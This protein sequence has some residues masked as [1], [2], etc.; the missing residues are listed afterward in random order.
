MNNKVIEKVGYIEFDGKILDVYSSLNKPLFCIYDVATLIGINVSDLFKLYDLIE[1][2][3]LIELSPTSNISDQ[4]TNMDFI[5]ET[6]LYNLLAQCYTDTARKWRRIITDELIT[7]RKARNMDILQ[8]FDMWNDMLDD[9]YIDEE[10]GI[11]MQSITIEG[12]DVTQ[13][14]YEG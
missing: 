5:T 6:G 1:A 14:P 11:L 10:T 7:L 12:G 9:L 4:Q 2:D 8:Q 13:V 3:E